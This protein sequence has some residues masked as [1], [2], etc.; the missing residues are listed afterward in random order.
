MCS[1]VFLEFCENNKKSEKFVFLK[2]VARL[3]ESFYKITDKLHRIFLKAVAS[4][5]PF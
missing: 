1:R 4:R 3:I 5:V 2:V